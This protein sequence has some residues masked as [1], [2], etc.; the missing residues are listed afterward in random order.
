MCWGE[1]NY[2]RADVS[3]VVYNYLDLH[4]GQLSF[5]FQQL[6]MFQPEALRVDS[7]GYILHPFRDGI[8]GIFGSDLIC[9]LADRLSYDSNGNAELRLGSDVHHIPLVE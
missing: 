9:D 5:S 6:Q 1:W 8:D 4:S 3:P 2:L 7:R